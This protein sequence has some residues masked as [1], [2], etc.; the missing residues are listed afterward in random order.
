MKDLRSEPAPLDTLHAGFMA[1]AARWPDRPALLQ[2]EER[3]TYAQ[4]DAAA[5]RLAAGL[6]A[7]SGA[8]KRVGVL[9][10]RSFTS[11]TGVL[12]A[13]FS[14]AA[15]IPLNPTLPI[16]RLRAIAEAAGLDAIICED[17][18]IALLRQLHN[19]RLPPVV[20]ADGA[21]RKI[22]DIYGLKALDSDDLH[23]IEPLRTPVR[24]ARDDIAYILFTSGSTGVPKGVPI[25]HA[26]AASFLNFNLARYRLEPE[27]VL[28]QTFEQSFDLSVFDIFMAWSAGASLYSFTHTELLAPLSVVQ[29][30]G[31]T[32]WFSVPSMIAMQLRLGTL[33]PGSLPT[34]RLSLFCGE[35]LV[36]E[37]AE[38]WQEAAP[39]SVLENLYGP[40]ELT[41]AC[42][43]HRWTREGSPDMCSNGIVP[44]GRLYEP[45]SRQIVDQD[46]EPVER[47]KV[48]ELCVAGPQTF[49]GYWR[50]PEASAAAFYESTDP[51][52]KSARF[53]RTGDLVRELPS[54]ELLFVGR[55]DHQVKLGGHRIELAEIEAALRAQPNVVE[56]AAFAWPAHAPVVEKIIASVSGDALDGETLRRR[57]RSVLPAYMV[58]ARIDILETMPRTSSGKLDKREL[59]DIAA[60][61]L[62]YSDGS[63]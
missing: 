1:S 38:A 58:P 29:S 52:G 20:L 60:M 18:H 26:N 55:R 48:G 21:R 14:G 62:R 13:L 39:A 50:N 19:G 42:A 40:T 57:L 30:R 2:G 36:R 17:K 27:D 59:S 37:H 16:S 63:L 31:I 25:S 6:L 61:G 23:V 56:A 46:L 12:G 54:G 49:A 43:A 35:P 33:L 44:I 22:E 24:V 11:Y 5:R 47:G 10:R 4:V 32:V 45:L 3:W 34:L 41:I 28:S 7:I 15:F 8:P 51:D 53:Y 9:A